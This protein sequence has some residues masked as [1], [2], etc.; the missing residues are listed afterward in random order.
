MNE[1][2][3]LRSIVGV[4]CVS[5][6]DG[7]GV[8]QR[9]QRA[10]Q[11]KNDITVSFADVEDVTTAFLNAAIGKLYGEFDEET[12]RLHLHVTDAEGDHRALLKRVVDRAKDFFKD[13]SKIEA[14]VREELG[15]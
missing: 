11:D 15:E 12:I 10:L 14:A 3:E 6:D 7:H 8:Y 5:S 1:V 9:I 13:P 2:V 4:N